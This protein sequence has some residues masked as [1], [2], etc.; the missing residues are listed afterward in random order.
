MSYFGH[1]SATNSGF[2][3]NLDEAVNWGNN[4]KYPV[5]LAN[6][7]YNGNIFQQSNSK[8]EEFVQVANLGA[9]S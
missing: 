4:G 1:A 7:C 5:M 2:E 9:I 8:S 6:S 3:I